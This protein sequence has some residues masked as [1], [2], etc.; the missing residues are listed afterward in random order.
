MEILEGNIL[1]KNLFERYS[2][3][4]RDWRFEISVSERRGSFFDAVVSNPN[5]V[6]QLK[7]DSIYKPIPLIIGTKIDVDPVKFSNNENAFSF[8][9]RKLDPIKL[10]KALYDV[11]DPESEDK[12][13]DSLASLITSAEPEVPKPN[14]SYAYGPF[15]FAQNNLTTVDKHQKN[16]SDELANRLREK[17]R[18]LYSSYG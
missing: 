1:A 5:E 11:H 8:G 17:L 7:I 12:D 9:Y 16:I 13:V 6:W 3:N 14:N 15:I 2:S 18:S 4:A 10:K